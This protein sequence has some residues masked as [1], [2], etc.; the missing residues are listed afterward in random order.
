[1]EKEQDNMK[2]A[3]RKRR[4]YQLLEKEWGRRWYLLTGSLRS[5]RKGAKRMEMEEIR[6]E[7]SL[8]AGT[9]FYSSYPTR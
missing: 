9:P 7:R 3:M 8:G 5:W 4:K 1:M 2:G 6:R